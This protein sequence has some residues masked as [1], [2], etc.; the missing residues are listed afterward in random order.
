MFVQDIEVDFKTNLKTFTEFLFH[1]KNVVVKTINGNQITGKE[2]VEYFKVMMMMMMVVMMIL[3][4]VLIMMM[5][6]NDLD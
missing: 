4:V 5:M 6:M 2:L 1:P 3:M